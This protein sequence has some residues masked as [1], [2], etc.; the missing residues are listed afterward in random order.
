M[1]VRDGPGDKK[2]SIK[3]VFYTA[4]RPTYPWRTKIN[5]LWWFGN[6]EAQPTDT[7]VYLYIRNFMM[8][9]KRFV[10]GVGDRSHWVTGKAPATTVMRSDIGEKGWQY[11]VIWIGPMPLLPFVS[12]S[13]TKVEWYLG[14]QPWGELAIKFNLIGAKWQLW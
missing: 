2:M 13:G 6:D 14:W 12:Y 7:F 8:N 9:F 5:P 1:L 3:T 4:D 10:V 11:S